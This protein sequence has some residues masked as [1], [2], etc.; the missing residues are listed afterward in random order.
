MLRDC[1]RYRCFSFKRPT[2]RTGEEFEEGSFR[3]AD[4]CA[5]FQSEVDGA[6]QEVSEVGSHQDV[7]CDNSIWGRAGSG[8]NSLGWRHRCSSTSSIGTECT[9]KGD[10]YEP[11]GSEGNN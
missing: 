1:S 3:K 2:L 11:D 5:G 7:H 10:S 8:L 4:D 6:G 9:E